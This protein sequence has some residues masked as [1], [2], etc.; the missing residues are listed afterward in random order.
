MSRDSNEGS[1]IPIDTPKSIQAQASGWLAKLDGSEPSPEDLRAFKVWVNQD[2]ANIAAFKKVA[3]A[4]DELNILTRLPS[5]L[6][7]QALQKKNRQQ[8][9]TQ[10]STQGV[11]GWGGLTQNLTAQR[12]SLRQV[13]VAAGLLIAVMIGLQS[14]FF[15]PQQAEYWT[16]VG[17][18]KTLSLPDGSEVVLNTNSRIRFDYRDEIRAVYLYQGEAHFT[19]AKNPA[20][21]FDV[22]AGVGLVRA[23]GTAFTVTLNDSSSDINVMVTEGVVEIAPEVVLP[24]KTSLPGVQAQSENLEADQSKRQRVAAGN[25]AT[26]D[27]S[28]IQT[29]QKIDPAEMRR[30]QAWQ[31]GLLIF[32]GESLEQVVAEVSRYTDTRIIIKSEAARSLR[33]GGQFKVGDTRAIFSAL[34]QGFGLKA[35]YATNSLV[36]LYYQKPYSNIE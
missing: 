1:V 15:A 14:S 3:A 16:A 12:L 13:A 8:K 31:Q 11:H 35:E 27:Q 5:L 24:Q 29:I 18:Q 4:W 34:E 7:Q 10:P 28:R 9:Q 26:F 32:S 22:Y 17:E 30:E 36:Y 6:E 33:I 21:P 20:R 19:V 25:A 23:I 2:P